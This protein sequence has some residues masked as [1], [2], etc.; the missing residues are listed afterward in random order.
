MSEEKQGQPVKAER[1]RPSFRQILRSYRLI[2]YVKPYKKYVILLFVG[3]LLF[4]AAHFLQVLV[5]KDLLSSGLWIP[6]EP[7]PAITIDEIIDRELPEN[8]NREARMVVVASLE[9]SVKDALTR[10]QYKEIKKDV[11]DL[12]A[13]LQAEAPENIVFSERIVPILGRLDKKEVNGSIR[14]VYKKFGN[15]IA[16]ELA[17]KIP[18]ADHQRFVSRIETKYAIPENS[19]VDMNRVVML[20]LAMAGIGLFIGIASYF[21]N[22]FKGFVISRATAD[23]RK[24]LCAH[25]LKLDMKFFSNRSSGDLISRQT[26][27]IVAGTKALTTLFTELAADPF[28]VIAY[29]IAAI[30]VCWELALIFGILLLVLPYPIAVIAHKIKKT[31]RKRLERIADLTTMMGEIFHGIRVTKAFTIEKEKHSEFNEANERY[32]SKLFKAFRLR[33]INDGLTDGF[34][35]ICIAI[36]MLAAA[37][38]TTRGI[39]GVRLEP[40]TVVTFGLCMVMVYKPIKSFTKAYPEFQ[41]S[42]AAS[43]RIFEVFD[44]QPSIVDDPEAVELSQIKESIVFD[45]VDFTY[46]DKPVLKNISF[47]INRGDIV[48]VVGHSGAGKSTLLDLIPRFYDPAEGSVKIDGIDLR[49][50]KVR[51]LREKIAVVSQDPFLFQTNIIENIRYGRPSATDEEV[52]AAAKAAN[53]HEFVETLPEGYQTICGERG[54]KLSGGQRQRITIARAILKDA[55]ILILD[56]ATSALD[57]ESER[58][59]R[60]ALGRLMSQRTTFVIAHRLSTVKHA[61]R[62]LVLR[63]GNLVEQGTHDTLLESRGEYCRLYNTEFAGRQESA[64]AGLT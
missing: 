29:A 64:E 44:V 40:P 58:L 38:I 25:L 7:P 60:E 9:D 42:A 8:I 20:S 47:K 30:Y 34:N 35:N 46:E 63:E 16:S 53:I 39:F 13:K 36:V 50:I 24:D 12:Q 54:T 52:L 45:K 62:I 15:R 23:I 28:E 56:E 33:A 43:E 10:D 17:E 4:S 3:I 6:P 1:E 2:T 61:N 14:R 21:K 19:K 37:V 32:V 5:M 31:G 48:A 51:S 26:N 27:D 49:K 22:Y 41:E 57:T 59:V 55:P 18:P 11:K